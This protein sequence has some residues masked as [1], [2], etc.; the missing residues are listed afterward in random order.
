[1][2]LHCAEYL[3]LSSAHSM[4]DRKYTLKNRISRVTLQDSCPIQEKSSYF[5][6]QTIKRGKPMKTPVIR[7]PI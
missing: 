2:L 4:L 6:V 5:E 7:L 1:M 3:F